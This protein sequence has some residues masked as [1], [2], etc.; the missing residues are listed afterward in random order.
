[1]DSKN[2]DDDNDSAM[3]E[4]EQDIKAV[5]SYE[6]RLERNRIIGGIAHEFNNLLMGIQG[7]LSLIFLDIAFS[8]RFYTKLKDMEKYVEGGVKLTEKLLDFVNDG[9]YEPEPKLKEIQPDTFNRLKYEMT[10]NIDSQMVKSH[11]GSSGSQALKIY[12]KVYTG[13]NTILL[14]DDDSMIVDVGKQ[15]LE[16]TG[17]E[18]ITAKSGEKAVEIY[19]K[20]HKRIDMVILDLIMPG[21]TGIDTYYEMKKINQDIKVL[22]SSGYRKNMDVNTILK[23]GRSAFIQKPFKMEQLTQEIGKI[24]EI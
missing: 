13:S 22:F 20:D 10:K 23:E 4:L 2:K 17:L 5:D 1:M 18:V 11:Y 12:E 21:M 7:N 8:D 16:R 19:K 24:L 6:K 14:V 3:N 15:M 9:T